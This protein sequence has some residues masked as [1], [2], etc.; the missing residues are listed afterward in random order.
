[1]TAA[2]ERD[3]ERRVIAVGVVSIRSGAIGLGSASLGC[4]WFQRL[5]LLHGELDGLG[6]VIPLATRAHPDGGAVLDEFPEFF[7]GLVPGDDFGG[8]RRSP[9]A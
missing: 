6:A 3:H 4:L 2:V 7:V 5:D 1:M 9:P 8:C